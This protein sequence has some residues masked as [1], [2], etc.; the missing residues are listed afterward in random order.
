MEEKPQKNSD[1]QYYM[2]ALRIAGDFG[3]AIAVPVVVLVYI[4]RF[5]D[6]KYGTGIWYTIAGFVTAALLS[7]TIIYRKAKKYGKEYQNLVDK[8]SK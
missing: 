5:L 7:G 4:G 3:A 2:F 6:A 8:N 1:R